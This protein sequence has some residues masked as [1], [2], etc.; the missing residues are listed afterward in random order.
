MPNTLRVELAAGS[1]RDRPA[2]DNLANPG[3]AA[4]AALADVPADS[5]AAAAKRVVDVVA[6]AFKPS[7]DGPES[8][9]V[10]FGLKITGEGSVV[11]AKVGSEMNLEVT[12]GWKR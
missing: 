2:N 3:D 6:S 1:Q 8:C 9:T 5:L 12:V 7:A 4:V 10:K 11:V